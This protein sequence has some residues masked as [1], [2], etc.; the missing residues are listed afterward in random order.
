[1]IPLAR[2]ILAELNV[3]PAKP[4]K[5]SL[6]YLDQIKNDVEIE[7]K[8]DGY[9][10]ILL[11]D[12]DTGKI[13]MLSS[14]GKPL[15]GNF[16]TIIK[17][18]K[19]LL[20]KG[21]VFSG[22]IC[23][24]ENP[25]ARN[26]AAKA[27]T[28]PKFSPDRV[29]YIVWNMFKLT[30]QLIKQGEIHPDLDAEVPPYRQ[31]RKELLTA[32]RKLRPK[33]VKISKRWKVT[34]HRSVQDIYNIVVSRGGEGVVAKHKKGFGAGM[35]VKA[36]TQLFV[37]PLVSF[38]I[39][40]SKTRGGLVNSLTV[41]TPYGKKFNVGGG[42]SDRVAQELTKLYKQRKGNPD[43]LYVGL[44]GEKPSIPI[45]KGGAPAPS[46]FMFLA[47]DKEGKHKIVESVGLAGK[48]LKDIISWILPND[49]SMSCNIQFMTPTG[50]QRKSGAFDN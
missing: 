12:P 13:Q 30:P 43:G 2:K 48:I 35:K 36:K 4:A 22:E 49:D 15:R 39:S 31:R 6:D 18:L 11:K 25:G 28:N 23:D 16:S 24:A 46:K 41:V 8:Y 14:S 3:K 26:M 29:L 17:Q 37:F 45:E 44:I 19:P 10:G 20:N 40:K 42:I 50:F 7:T 27:A 32:L 33:N 34:P 38:N 47:T 5:V 21:Y 1:M 9:R